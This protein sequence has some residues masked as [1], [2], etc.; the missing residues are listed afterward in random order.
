MQL[1]AVFEIQ[2]HPLRSD[3]RMN[4]AFN[5]LDALIRS[6]ALTTLD[7]ADPRASTFAPGAVPIV[8]ASPIGDGYEAIPPFGVTPLPHLQ[9]PPNPWYVPSKRGLY[10]M[11]DV[12]A[13][14]VRHCGC[15]MYSLGYS[16]PRSLEL[17][18]TWT[19]M[20][21]WPV[22][23]GA[24]VDEGAIQKEECRRLVWGALTL[25]A[26]HNSVMV[27]GTDKEHQALWIKD[28]ANVR[29]HIGSFGARAL[30]A[31]VGSTHCCSPGKRSRAGLV[32]RHR[33]TRCGR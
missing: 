26:S 17:V 14:G 33:R 27:A 24:D 1:F 12:H 11:E 8:P 25:A 19:V 22:D 5:L 3:T 23:I 31:D 9:A 32:C 20:P 6:L 10:T 30:T 29:A 7:A 2:A 28:A 21:A 13:G 15:G 18:P 4:A 16:W